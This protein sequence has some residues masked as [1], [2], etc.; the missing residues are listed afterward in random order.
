MTDIK[1][2][3]YGVKKLANRRIFDGGKSWLQY[4]RNR[5]NQT[6]PDRERY[7]DDE[8]VKIIGLHCHL[9]LQEVD[10]FDNKLAFSGIK[11]AES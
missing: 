3:D 5:A 11:I 8:I 7:C 2:K 4:E 6:D 9:P 1:S 10:Y